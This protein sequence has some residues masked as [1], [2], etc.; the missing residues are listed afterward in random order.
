MNAQCFPD[1]HSTNWFDGWISCEESQNPNPERGMSHWIM[2]DLGRPWLLK[3]IHI[4][5]ANDPAHLD[6][7]I[8]EAVFEYSLD[9]INWETLD[10][11]VIAQATGLPNYEGGSGPDFNEAEAQ[12]ILITA[13]SS[14]GGECVG[15]S[16]IRINADQLV[17]SSDIT[18][19]SNRCF[20]LL[21]TPNPFT[22]RADVIVRT[23]CEGD[24]Q[25]VLTDLYGKNV[26]SGVIQRWALQQQ[27]NYREARISLKGEQLTPGS[28]LLQIVSG[29]EIEV[30]KIIRTG[31]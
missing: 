12:F 18:Q 9:G 20:D 14:W 26:K 31:N 21:V 7:G 10:S 19:I 24:I 29:K 3:D 4:W 25:Y 1:R 2:Y 15:F 28:Y 11:M 23:Q 16:E 27:G 22:Y 5:N 30:I 8:Q 13:K 17:G 6:W